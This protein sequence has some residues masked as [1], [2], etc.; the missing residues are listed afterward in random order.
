MAYFA[1]STMGDHFDE[2]CN[3]CIHGFDDTDPDPKFCPIVYL[4]LEWN[5]SQNKNKEQK[6]ALDILVPQKNLVRLIVGSLSKN[7]I[8]LICSNRN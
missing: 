5:Y 2:Q 8:I 4:Q 7:K 3:N 6:I 1:N